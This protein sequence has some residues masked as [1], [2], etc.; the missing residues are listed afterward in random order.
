VSE[1]RK[2]DHIKL[3]F[4]SI[5]ST[6]INLGG[7]AYEPIFSAHPETGSASKKFLDKNFGLP[8]WVS[9]MT[10]GTEKAKLINTNLAKA[11]GEFK[12]GMGLGSCRCLLEDDSRLKDFDVKKYMG[13]MPLYTNLGIAQLEQL[14]LAD[15]LNLVIELN[16]K[17]KAD[18]LI[19]HVNPLQEWAQPEGD[20]YTRPPIETIMRVIDA[21]K[22]PIIVKEVGQGFGPKSLESLLKL[23]LRAIELAGFGGTNFTMLEQARLSAADSGTLPVNSHFAHIGHTVEDM[24]KNLNKLLKPGV[25]DDIEIIISGGVNNC[26]QAHV[27]MESLKFNNVVGMAGSLLK[28]SMGEYEELQTYVKELGEG[29][30][31]AKAFLK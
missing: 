25:N 29:I 11:C 13:E 30:E 28:H 2:S 8:L 4:Q 3:S 16:A 6:Q 12:L 18:G 21:V 20:R 17:L 10:G 5:P 1:N 26:V 31:L 9:S 19:I 15:K 7:L 24:I 14:I 27:L 22:C 23:P